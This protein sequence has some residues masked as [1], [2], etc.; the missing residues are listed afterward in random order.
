MPLPPSPI[1]PTPSV[2]M[3]LSV[4]TP[5]GSTPSIHS[6]IETIP[7]QAPEPAPAVGPSHILTHDV[8]RLLSYIHEVDQSRSTEHLELSDNIRAI[9]EE[10]L[11]IHGLLREREEQPQVAPPPAP[12]PQP[13]LI[14]VPV[15]APAP[16]P[17]PAIQAP[18]PVIQ[19]P[20]PSTPTTILIPV[21]VPGPV[22]VPTILP[23]VIIQPE[24][25]VRVVYKDASVSARSQ[26]STISES[27]RSPLVT[28]RPASASPHF[29]V[30]SPA[31]MSEEL[32]PRPASVHDVPQTPQRRAAS[33]PTRPQPRLVPIPLSPPPL[34]RIPSI[35][36]LSDSQ[37]FLSSHHSDD[38]SLLEYEDYPMRAASP[39]WPSSSSSSSPM[40]SPSSSSISLR[41]PITGEVSDVTAESSLVV[42]PEQ[43][44]RVAASPSPSSVSSGTARPIPPVNFSHLRELL[45]R[46]GYQ[47][48]TLEDGQTHT[49]QVLE[50]L[51]SRPTVV[52]DTETCEKL[53]RIEEMLQRLLTQQISQPPVISMPTP[54]PITV[55]V[56]LAEP[57]PQRMAM[58]EPVLGIDTRAPTETESVTGSVPV[59]EPAPII[60]PGV[61]PVPPP[62]APPLIVPPPGVFQPA[63]VPARD[64]SPSSVS[65]PQTPAVLP[66]PPPPQIVDQPRDDISETVSSSSG[67]SSLRRRIARFREELVEQGREHPTLHMPTPIRIGP[68]FDEQLA[69]MLTVEAPPG[70]PPVQP[71]PPITPLVYRPG[72]RAPRPRSVSPTFDTDLPF[73]RSQSAPVM[74]PIIIERPIRAEPRA[75][76]VRDR[77]HRPQVG[78]DG[79]SQPP[80][81]QMPADIS[82]TP[83]PAE[84]LTETDR[85]SPT[86]QFHDG[87]PIRAG[88]RRRPM[89]SGVSL[90]SH[91]IH[92]SLKISSRT[93][94]G[95]RPP[96]PPWALVGTQLRDQVGMDQDVSKF[97]KVPWSV[98]VYRALF[99]CL[100][101]S[102][103]ISQARLSLLS[104]LRVILEYHQEERLHLGYLL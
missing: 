33:P 9:R 100:S 44:P 101:S 103:P 46:L 45:D 43:T 79:V 70:Q 97:R 32:P 19:A 6:L 52:Q 10:L 41:E 78:G 89:P 81:P 65:E 15:L 42:T 59:S 69:D 40:S 77:V 93:D 84:S 34:R 63:F 73:T 76:Q 30:M 1:P 102:R 90:S 71:P 8:N 16:A 37:S 3:S 66:V 96:L 27:T 94:P 99:V 18:A 58:P 50:D 14:P 11:D 22:Q 56:P 13:Q 12:V 53:R 61:V 62:G 26:V 95:H 38:M 85:G 72:P 36:T 60:E 104:L 20:A 51:R 4:S 17:V 75:R 86:Y 7:S 35:E 23:P 98:F 67:A 55:P 5:R 47:I 24:P 88:T 57:E 48:S 64:V 31:P 49:H 54:V 82:Q 83:G 68:S 92:G 29:I 25:P 74:D 80:M 21:P 39:S 28:P 87:R 2:S 91:T